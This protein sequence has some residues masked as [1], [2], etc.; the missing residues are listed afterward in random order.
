M[1]YLREVSHTNSVFPTGNLSDQQ[2]KRCH[3]F[4]HIYC[5]FMY[6]NHVSKKILTAAIS[7]S[8]WLTNNWTKLISL[9]TQAWIFGFSLLDLKVFFS[10]CFKKVIWYHSICCTHFLSYTIPQLSILILKITMCFVKRL[11]AK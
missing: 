1:W 3:K 2:G 10:S 11:S 8:I 5:I 6:L 4:R 9:S 7:F